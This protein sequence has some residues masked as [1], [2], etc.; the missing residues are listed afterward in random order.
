MSHFR[1][2]EI[3]CRQQAT[4][5]ATAADSTAFIFVRQAYLDLEQGWLLLAQRANPE[6]SADQPALRC[7]AFKTFIERAHQSPT[8]ESRGRRSAAA[9]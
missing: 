3:Y 9:H 6:G 5:C 8:H 2:R 7:R 1:G 4:E